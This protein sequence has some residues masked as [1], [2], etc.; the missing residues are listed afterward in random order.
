M[1]P[2]IFGRIMIYNGSLTSIR[3]TAQLEVL[4]PGGG[5]IPQGIYES[6]GEKVVHVKLAKNPNLETHV[7]AK[8]ISFDRIPEASQQERSGILRAVRVVPQEI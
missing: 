2:K 5:V 6:C 4:S 8:E 1:N 3:T 7:R